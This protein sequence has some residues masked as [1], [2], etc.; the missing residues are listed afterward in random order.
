M[1]M[2]SVVLATYNEK[3]NLTKLVPLIEDIFRKER[4]KGEIIVVDD[5]SPDGTSNLARKFNRR[6]HNV[7]LLWRPR[8]MGP[9]SAHWDGYKISK[10]NIVVGMDVDSHDP[11]DIPRFV[12]KINQGY[13]LVVNSRFIK[14]GKY[15]IK[16]FQ[17]LKKYI[18]S[19]SGNI[20]IRFLSGVPIHD[21]TCSMRAVRK[22]VIDN[23]ETESKGN[24]FFMEFIVK[25]YRKGYRITEIPIVFRDRDIGKSKLKLGKQSFRMLADLWKYTR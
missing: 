3:E 17:T 25:A 20:L 15:E 19:R 1:K 14:G 22:E 23:I 2:V 7:R 9:G 21:F 8:K 10:G 6:Y 12:R 11:N 24:S 16:S 4:M 18:A 5:N 13:D